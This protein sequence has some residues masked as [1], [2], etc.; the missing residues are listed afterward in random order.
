MNRIGF[1]I[2][3]TGVIAKHHARAILATPDA[4]LVSVFA[5]D[6]DKRRA[7]AEQ[8]GCATAASLEE[9]V[10]DPAVQVVVIATP[11]G[12][13]AEQAIAA[14]RAGKHVLCEKPLD[15][16]LEKTDRI[17]AACAEHGVILCPVFQNRFG[18]HVR[19]IKRAVDSGRLGRLL[20]GRAT[21]KWQRTREYYQSGS[22]RGTRALDGGGCLMNQGIHT[23][24]LLL[25]LMGEPVEVTGYADTLVHSGIEVEDTACAVVRFASGAM[26]VIEATTATTP[27]L[28]AG[29]ELT[30][31]R[32]TVAM[33]GEHLSAWEV[34]EPDADDL[35]VRAGIDPRAV[36]PVE[37]EARF[38]KHRR[39]LDDLIGAIRAGASATSIPAADGR[40]A[41]EIV[42]GIYRSA[43]TGAPYR[44]ARASAPG[45]TGQRAP[46]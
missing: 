16:T 5:R 21:V 11:S 31:S 1:A 34:A 4:R 35:A 33:R 25:H 36:E 24:D 37:D 23:V 26:G 20:L 9:L 10:A 38:P 30:G 13:H 19:R 45:N 43:E 8:H 18:D 12:A 6:A 27:Q 22:W 28:P 42:L 46:A 2:A 41:L 44:F 17:V 7:F 32:G 3:G 40:L 39:Q 14:A 15:I 29:I